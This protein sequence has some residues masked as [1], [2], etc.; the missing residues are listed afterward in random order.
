MRKM[1]LTAAALGGLLAMTTV[2]AS[3]APFTA[4]PHV[5]ANHGLVTNVDYYY[6]HHHYHH[7][8]WQHDH[9]RYY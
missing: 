8:H 9:W 7:R 4:G 2:N 6:N 3:A 5:A 1:L